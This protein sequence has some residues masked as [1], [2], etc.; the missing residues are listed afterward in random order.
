MR[1]NSSQS[2]VSLLN[3]STLKY[4]IVKLKYL[5]F[6][7]FGLNIHILMFWKMKL[8]IISFLLFSNLYLSWRKSLCFWKNIFWLVIYFDGG[9]SM[10]GSMKLKFSINNLIEPLNLSRPNMASRADNETHKGDLL[11]TPIHVY[12]Y[13]HI[14]KRFI[15]EVTQFILNMKYSKKLV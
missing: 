7:T 1:L 3:I 10:N 4:Y 2:R 9:R 13:L 12:S 15:L 6:K 11:F 8:L 5:F 14:W